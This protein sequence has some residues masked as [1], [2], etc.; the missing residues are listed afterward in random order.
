MYAE[1]G[2]KFHFVIIY[3]IEAHPVGSPSPYSGKEWT[4]P[5]STDKEGCSLTQPET[6]E[7]RVAQASQM[8][9]ELGI[10]VPVLIDEMDNP[11]WCT[12][13]QAP[14]NAY[15]VDTSGKII[16]TESWY[17][18]QEMAAAM[19]TF[20]G[21]AETPAP[22]TKLP[23]IPDTSVK[24]VKDIEYGRGGD[25]PLLLDIYIPETPIMSPMPAIIFIHGGGWQSGDKY[26]SQV[27]SLLEN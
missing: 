11:V 25:I 10:T 6:Y 19:E 4:G 23:A 13:G 2:D 27:R 18:P 7:E 21:V 9:E 22:V 12:Y 24:V 15:L 17:Q 14:N 3:T 20:L 5:A 8:V 26:P 1:Y 16:E